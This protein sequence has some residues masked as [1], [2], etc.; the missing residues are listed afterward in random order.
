MQ[1]DP[2]Y[3]VYVISAPEWAVIAIGIV[4][5]FISLCGLG[6][7]IYNR[8][9]SPLKIKQIPVLTCNLLST[10]FFSFF[11]SFLFSFHF[12]FSFS[13]LLSSLN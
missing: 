3:E 10:F 13:F 1:P 5:Y 2:E 6:F 11:L 12:S 8:D 9:Y 4:F 7:V